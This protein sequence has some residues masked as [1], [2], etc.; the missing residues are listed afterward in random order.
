MDQSVSSLEAG[1]SSERLD[2]T[3][4]LTAEREKP[5]KSEPTEGSF[6]GGA[7]TSDRLSMGQTWAANLTFMA[8]NGFKTMCFADSFGAI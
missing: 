7:D 2:P 3:A 8:E 5:V 1:E 4:A 6:T